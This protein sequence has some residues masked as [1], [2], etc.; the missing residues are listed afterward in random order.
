MLG[1]IGTQRNTLQFK[2]GLTMSVLVFVAVFMITLLAIRREHKNF[3]RELEEQATLLLMGFNFVSDDALYALDVEYL[4]DL[5]DKVEHSNLI[6]GRVYDADGRVIA[7]SQIPGNLVYSPQTDSFGLQLLNSSIPIF[8]WQDEQLLAGQRV[9]AGRATIGALSLTLPTYQLETKTALAALEGVAIAALITCGALI[10]SFT[11]TR[12]IT[13]PLNHLIDAAIQ[14]GAQGYNTQVDIP[15]ED[16]EVSQLARV[17]NRM[18]S[19]LSETITQLHDKAQ[20]LQKANIKIEDALRFK[21]QILANVSHDART[22]LSVIVIRA[23]MLMAGIH[24]QIASE[25][26]CQ[27]ETILQNAK[28]L[29]FFVNN[30]LDGAQLDANRLVL[31]HQAIDIRKWL[32]NVTTTMAVLAERKGLYFTLEE[33]LNLPPVIFGDAN[34]LQQIVFNLAGNAAK[35][36]DEGGITLRAFCPDRAHWC[37]E[38]TDTGPGIPSEA[39]P[40]LFEAFYQIDSTATRVK[41]QGV[42]LGLS[43]VKQMVDLMGGQIKVDSLVGKGSTFTVILPLQTEKANVG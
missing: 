17:F 33:N 31:T 24:G 14:L 7:D 6:T 13:R 34:R 27:I 20:E 3:R 35:F 43:I 19:R 37:L 30:L 8:V 1:I 39:L 5:M 26:E 36:T 38:I 41:M 16:N 28:Q 10:L 32:W 23:E 15:N 21:S 9:T 42:G 12:T 25:Q 4:G 29:E 22:P 18:S 2:I 11:V 40:Q